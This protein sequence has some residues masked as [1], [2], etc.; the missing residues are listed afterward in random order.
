MARLNAFS[1]L[2]LLLLCV[3]ICKGDWCVVK[4]TASDAAMQSFIDSACS[5]GLDCSAIKPGGSCFDPNILRS[6]ASYML[7]LNYRKNNV[8]QQDIGTIAITDPSY[9]SCHYP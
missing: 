2:F 4:F 6:H 8:C 3:G 9:G 7:A 1:F 5:S